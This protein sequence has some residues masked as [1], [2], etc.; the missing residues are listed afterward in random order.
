MKLLVSY[1]QSGFI[2][3]IRKSGKIFEEKYVENG[4]ESDALVDKKIISR[5][6]EFS[7]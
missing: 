2:A 4:T 3:E 5:A 6:S 1:E 7:I